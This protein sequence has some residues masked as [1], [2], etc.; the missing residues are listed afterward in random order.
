MGYRQMFMSQQV[1]LVSKR[2]LL[3]MLSVAVYPLWRRTVDAEV[4]YLASLKW[5][6]TSDKTEHMA[7]V[8]VPGNCS[9]IY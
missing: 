2:L 6:H 9:K 4:E 5:R 1:T 7:P 3:R 8:M